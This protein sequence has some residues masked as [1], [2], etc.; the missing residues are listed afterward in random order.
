M[1]AVLSA[2]EQEIRNMVKEMRTD[3]ILEFGECK[4][5]EG[6]YSRKSAL[7]VST[8][9]GREK[10]EQAAV[11]VMDNYPVSLV[12]S[13]GFSG[14]LN[15]R[16]RTGDI[17]VCSKIRCAEK[18]NIVPLPDLECTP[19]TARLALESAAAPAVQGCGITAAVICSTAA[20][21]HRLGIEYG[22]DIVDMESYWIGRLA[23]ERR[24]SFIA[25]RSILDSQQD[26]LSFLERVTSGGGIVPSL[27][28]RQLCL[29]PGHWRETIG[30]Y[31]KY[32]LAASSLV[33]FMKGLIRNL[34][35][36]EI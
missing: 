22:A 12:I 10:A 3:R 4:I 33:I 16:S 35:E 25:V 31:R 1:L 11:R 19:R 9:M 26:D 6:V 20:A 23:L 15:G 30:I 29:H 24:I 34:P 32:R 8:G 14:A 7:L 5:R 17:V 28:F 27:V 13:T 21:K 36:T 2:L 18:N